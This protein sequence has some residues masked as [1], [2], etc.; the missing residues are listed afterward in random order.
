MRGEGRGGWGLG[1]CWEGGSE[2]KEGVPG[3]ILFADLGFG[4][5]EGM[6]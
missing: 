6:G 4:R 1:R 5:G 3:M 2:R